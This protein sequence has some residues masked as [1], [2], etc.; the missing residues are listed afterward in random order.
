VIALNAAAD[1][2]IIVGACAVAAG[3][4]RIIVKVGR[5]L[6]VVHEAIIGR[7]AGPGVEKIPS[8]VERFEAIDVRTRRVEAEVTLNSGGSLKD[9][10]KQ[11]ADRLDTLLGE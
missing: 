2:A 5:R 3:L 7:P 1:W 10:A 11:T 6:F 8:M 9:L 4:L